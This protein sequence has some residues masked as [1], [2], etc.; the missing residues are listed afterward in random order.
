MLMVA[1]V[2]MGPD[3]EPVTPVTLA[4][5]WHRI[6]PKEEPLDVGE[7]DNGAMAFPFM[8]ATGMVGH[9]P[10]PVPWGD[11]EGPAMCAWHW[12]DAVNVLRGHT[13][14]LVVGVSGEETNPKNHAIRLTLLTAAVCAAAPSATAVYWGSGTSVSPA[15]RFIQ[16][17]QEMTPDSLPLLS[18]VEFRVIPNESGTAWSVITTGL[19][20]IG[21]MEIEVREAVGEP[22]DLVDR[23]MNIA[24][25]M[26]DVGPILKD[27]DTVGTSAD[28]TLLIHHAHSIWE[29]DETV[30]W[31]EM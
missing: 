14:H 9:M 3:A 10:V 20:A 29:R 18:W 24:A 26:A 6:W 22:L 11:L 28:E 8:D 21:L 25:Y 23:V 15:D 13:S 5:A 2:M 31:I 19:K 27:G 16:L 7:G 1:F 4:D 17:A 30:L 12:P